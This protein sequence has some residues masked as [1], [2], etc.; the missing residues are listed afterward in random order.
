MN[1]LAKVESERELSIFWLERLQDTATQK[2]PFITY[3]RARHIH[4]LNMPL[5]QV[6]DERNQDCEE[7]TRQCLE[8]Q[9]KPDFTLEPIHGVLAAKRS[10]GQKT[11]TY[12]ALFLAMFQRTRSQLPFRTSFVFLDDFMDTLDLHATEALQR[13]L[14]LYVAARNM[15]AFWMTGRGTTSS[16]PTSNQSQH[17][18][19]LIPGIRGLKKPCHCKYRSITK[20]FSSSSSSSSSS[21]FFV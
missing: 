4:S 1:E 19:D 14:Q 9:S 8:F 20:A 2:G 11:R 16:S 12:L 10:E 6:L 17:G 21:S 18:I 5:A 3:C 15:Q 13:C 7:V